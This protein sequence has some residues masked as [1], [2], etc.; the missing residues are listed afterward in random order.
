MMI[1]AVLRRLLGIFII[2]F[3]IG[4]AYGR[5]KDYD[6][7]GF[8]LPEFTHTPAFWIGAAVV[9]VW[10]WVPVMQPVSPRHVSMSQEVP[11]QFSNPGEIQN[12]PFQMNGQW[13]IIW[14]GN[15]MKS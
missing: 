2:L 3:A 10:C 14:N 8:D 5:W 13:F 4:Y 7:S 15:Y 6:I 1:A 11:R 12:E 9:S